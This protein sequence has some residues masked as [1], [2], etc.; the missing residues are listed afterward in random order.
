M[1]S[2]S[3]SIAKEEVE[4]TKTVLDALA[5]LPREAAIR[6]I[7]AVSTLLGVSLPSA[8]RSLRSAGP[9]AGGAPLPTQAQPGEFPD[10]ASLVAAA[11]PVDGPERALVVAYWKQVREEQPE[12]TA[13][14]VNT[15][16]KHMGE[17]LPNVTA[18][19]N[20]LKERKPALV[21][22]VKKAGNSRQARKQYKLT[23]AGVRQ[24]E[25]ML[26]RPETAE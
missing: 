13:Q 19:L 24:V 1:S 12:W 2:T 16:L 23:S 9:A 4:A 15:E 7:A 6:V 3:D 14:W 11:R 8:D 20:L 17:R 10:L 26:A 25:Q 22:Q 21:M 5:D 18:T